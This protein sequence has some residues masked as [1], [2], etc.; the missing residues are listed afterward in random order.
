MMIPPVFSEEPNPARRLERTR[1]AMRAAK[2]RQHTVP[3]TI[4]QDANHLIPPF[5][6]ARTT[7]V[8]AKIAA[9]T[10]RGAAANLVISNVPGARDRQY[11]AGVRLEAMFPFSLIF[12]GL[13]LN[14]TVVSYCDQV[15]WGVNLDPAQIDDAWGLIHHVRGAQA[16][17]LAC[18]T[19]VGVVPGEEAGAIVGADAGGPGLSGQPP[20]RNL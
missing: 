19:S 20:G 4:L 1:D 17:L 7:R 11:L 2:L 5:L 6:L 3:A 9:R 16:S 18:V 14:V 15:D 8:L 13:G 10:R 12:H